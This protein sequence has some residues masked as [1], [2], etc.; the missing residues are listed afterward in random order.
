MKRRLI[1]LMLSL[2][3]A[4]APMSA[5]AKT[6]QEDAGA[7]LLQKIFGK[8]DDLSDNNLNL[9][10]HDGTQ[11]S[12]VREPLYLFENKGQVFGNDGAFWANT[13]VYITLERNFSI[14]GKSYNIEYG[15]KPLAMSEGDFNSDGRKNQLA[16]LVAAKTT[17]NRS[18]LLL[19]V[20]KADALTFAAPVAVLYEGSADFFD[21][22]G[23]F[24]N[25]MEIVCA[26]VNGDRY[27]E[28]VTATPTNLRGGSSVPY[29]FDRY[30]G[31][32]LW[33]LKEDGRTA[34][35]W[36]E[37]D[38]WESEPAF[39]QNSLQSSVGNSYL[40]APGVTASMAAADI[41]GDGYDDLVT[42]IS[43]AK[44]QYTP[45]YANSMY[46]LY[47]IGGAP[48]VSEMIYEKRKNLSWNIQ[49]ALSDLS[50]SATSG[51]ASGFDVTICD[52]DNSR[53][54]HHFYVPQ[55]NRPC[56]GGIFGRENVHAKLL[57]GCF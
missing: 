51:E 1:S 3:C 7:G 33:K 19:C 14:N 10:Y 4:V 53:H 6:T 8:L 26:D 36:K 13:N 40:G 30:G 21:N 29:G 2:A 57:C 49:N 28:I 46:A 50:L 11:L 47:Y 35:S 45:T 20:T 23:E 39:I 48:T 34:L 24:V 38:G 25:C 52:I 5:L 32:Y 18:L 12:D 17:D 37:A 15:Y 31:S 55:G 41:D 9:P 56:L 42:A 27:D 22:I 43:S 44:V 54:T 16:V